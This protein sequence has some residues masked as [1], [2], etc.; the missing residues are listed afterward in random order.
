[1]TK[2]LIALWQ[3][4]TKV[5][6]ADDLWEN[7]LDILQAVYQVF[8]EDLLTASATLGVALAFLLINRLGRRVLRAFRLSR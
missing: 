6:R 8:T 1:M 5:F 7:S 3:T 2:V 4:L